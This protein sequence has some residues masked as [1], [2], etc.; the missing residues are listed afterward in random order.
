MEEKS[1]L[2]HQLN[3]MLSEKDELQLKMEALAKENRILQLSLQQRDA[4][5]K[6]QQHPQKD[7]ESK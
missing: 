2:T 5:L 3:Q 7:S 4:E 1:A 6:R